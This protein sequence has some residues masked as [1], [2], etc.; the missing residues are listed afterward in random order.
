MPKAKKSKSSSSL[1]KDFDK[2]KTKL[3]KGK[4]PAASNATNTSFKA[5]SIAL[6]QQSITKDRSSAPT[7][8]RN[9]TVEELIG[10]T[11]HYSASVRRD[12][13]VGLK[14]IYKLH[15][16]LGVRHLG[17]V[18]PNVSRLMSDEDAGVRTSLH[19]FL[20]FYLASVPLTALQPY[21]STLLLY[22]T[23]ALSH[24]Y[25]DIRLDAVRILDLLYIALGPQVTIGWQHSMHKSSDSSQPSSGEANQEHGERV[26]RCYL[27]LLGLSSSSTSSI[28]ATSSFVVSSD[29]S[30]GARML[31]LRS[32]C[33][34]FFHA[35]RED[36]SGGSSSGNGNGNGNSTQT[37]PDHYLVCPTWFFDPY[38]SS[39]PEL[40]AFKIA[41]TSATTECPQSEDRFDADETCIAMSDLDAFMG[42][43]WT[44]VQIAEGLESITTLLGDTPVSNR[45]KEIN[46]DSRRQLFQIL[47]PLLLSVFF[48]A[49]PT[50][51]SPSTFSASS[52]TSSQKSL[53]TSAQLVCTVA[54]LTLA[55]W[56]GATSSEAEPVDC[57]RR[58]LSHMAAYFPFGGDWDQGSIPELIELNLC[59]CEL[60]GLLAM[61]Q[62]KGK[63]EVKRSSSTTI[64]MRNV[65][66]FIVKLLLEEGR[67]D[68]MRQPLL[69]GK[70]FVDLL[71]S[72]WLLLNQKSLGESKDIIDAL[73]V[74]WNSLKAH[75]STKR[76]GAEFLGRLWLL[77]LQRSYHGSF[78]IR[79]ASPHRAPLVSWLTQSLPRYLWELHANDAAASAM[80]LELLRLVACQT[81]GLII[82]E[83]IRH[84]TKG[85]IS[86]PY[87]RLPGSV[88]RTAR[89]LLF[90]L[91]S[92]DPILQRAANA[93]G[94]VTLPIIEP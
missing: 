94:A 73:L 14:D 76:I 93:V 66:D 20:S 17:L 23:S 47:S 9:L 71:P 80:T 44:C 38:F 33:T 27:S 52:S 41:L 83:K 69:R 35:N 32:M 37:P 18:I 63:K 21:S 42:R 46:R 61:T 36:S 72:I 60:V 48:D 65:F 26:L 51:F 57:L 43:S 58:L 25:P 39:L 79:P 88:Q 54:T 85:V 12:A 92:T 16:G 40:S 74:H 4:K 31:I 11:R 90:T 22:T 7:S 77:P 19:T 78:T 49:A 15:D 29:L 13:L 59:Y 45:S 53:S 34:F 28:S 24:I 2:Q 6:T 5:R 81:D 50:A 70:T 3:G 91:Q 89:G 86:G 68:R 64:Q 62:G 56:R 75:D 67:Q 84:P 1:V 55:L 87:S 10:Q 8:K 30:S 82:N